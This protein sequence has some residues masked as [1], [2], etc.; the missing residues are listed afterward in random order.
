[1]R[2][3]RLAALVAGLTT[4]L[5]LSVSARGANERLRFTANAVSLGGPGS[6]SGTAQLDIVIERFS[7]EAERQRLLAAL[8]KNNQD[9]LLRTLQDL[10][11]VGTIRTPR[12]VGYDLHYAHQAPGED[13]G[14]RIFI[15]TDR[16]IGFREAANRPRTIDYPFTFI[17]L[18][19]NSNGEG[20]GKLSLA[21]RVTSS[22]DGKVVELENYAAQPVMLTNVKRQG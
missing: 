7:T 6:V 1:M 16:P 20:E 14:Q 8:K 21:T 19:L 3:L 22:N 4:A 17:E 18:R 13:G 15:A 11:P 2:R 5:T 10:K 9:E 12:S